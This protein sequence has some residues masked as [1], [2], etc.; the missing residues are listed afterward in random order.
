MHAGGRHVDPELAAEAIAAGDSPLTPREADVLELAAERRADRRDRRPG[1]ALARHGAQLPLERDH[2][3]RRG[4][5]ARG[6]RHRAAH[7]LDLSPTVASTS[8]VRGRDHADE[9]EQRC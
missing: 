6:R 8:S 5:P 3:A 4:Q 1:L 9:R 2:Q 7:G